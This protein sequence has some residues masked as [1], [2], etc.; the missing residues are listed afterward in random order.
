MDLSSLFSAIDTAVKDAE[1][2]QAALTTATAV[3]D[4]AVVALKKAVDD[5]STAQSTATLVYQQS[6]EAAQAA[7]RALD[8]A[9]AAV[10]PVAD[11]RVRG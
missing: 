10:L 3:K 11:P 9:L 2:K 6:V 7:R 8:A 4:K 5:A 1:T